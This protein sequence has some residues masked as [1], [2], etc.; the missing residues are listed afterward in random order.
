MSC[1][2]EKTCF[3]LC[4]KSKT[5]CGNNN[6]RN[7]LNCEKKLNCAILAAKD[8]PRTLQEIG[9]LHGLTRMRI[10]QI[11]KNAI[12]KLGNLFKKYIVN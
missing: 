10:C 5:P 9:D 2:K 3:S 1:N 7:W 4:E 11:E 8:G 12:K 6:C